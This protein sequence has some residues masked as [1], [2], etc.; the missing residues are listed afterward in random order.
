[1]LPASSKKF[2]FIRSI[3]ETMFQLKWSLSVKKK[4]AT[5]SFFLFTFTMV[6]CNYNYMRTSLYQIIC[7]IVNLTATRTLEA[8]RSILPCSTFTHKY[9]NIAMVGPL[10]CIISHIF[11]VLPTISSYV[12]LSNPPLNPSLTTCCPHG[13]PG[14]PTA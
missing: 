2:F 3:K 10:F 5:N 13:S 11:I 7:I 12:C 8:I 14:H 4:V 6:R 1:M 9:T